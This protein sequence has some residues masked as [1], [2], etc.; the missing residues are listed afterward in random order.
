M[1]TDTP[2][3][4]D[5]I[6]E[7]VYVPITSVVFN[8][9]VKPTSCYQWFY[10]CSDLIEINDIENLDTS[11]CTDM[12]QMFYGCKALTSLDVSHFDT[13]NV[14]SMYSMFCN[15]R[16]LISLDVSNFNTEKVFY[17]NCMFDH[18]HSRKM[19]QGSR[20]F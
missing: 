4:M 6:N 12:S 16:N 1:F 7:D 10:C 8:E 20:H 5:L 13:K 14:E 19:N 3:S 18:C 11:E 9:T 15:C 17:M 2:G